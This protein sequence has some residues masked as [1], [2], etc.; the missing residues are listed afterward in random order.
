LLVDLERRMRLAGIRLV[1]LE[2]GNFQAE[3]L[4]LYQSAGYVRRGP[5]GEYEIDPLSVF[6]EKQL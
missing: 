4:Q 3:A 2:T 6:M 5:F 1:R